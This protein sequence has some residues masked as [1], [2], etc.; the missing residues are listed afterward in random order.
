MNIMIHIIDYL[1]SDPLRILTIIGGSGGLLYFYDRIRNR[2]R[3]IIRLF[4]TNCSSDNPFKISFD[5]ENLGA[6]QTSLEPHIE[7]TAYIYDNKYNHTITDRLSKTVKYIFV[8]DNKCIRSLPPR[9]PRKM[10]ATCYSNAFFNGSFHVLC[11]CKF[12][13]STGHTY[14]VRLRSIDDKRLSFWRYVYEKYM[15][16]LFRRLYFEERRS[17]Y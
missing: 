16:I 8:V 4:E 1:T 13:I 10:H 15:Y 3:I 11:I 6:M 5:V 2:T 12:S 7:L 9:E 17:S 14:K